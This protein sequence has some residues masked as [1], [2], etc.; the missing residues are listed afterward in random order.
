[1][2]GSKIPCNDHLSQNGYGPAHV[3]PVA[4]AS[5]RPIHQLR[6]RTVDG[7]LAVVS[8]QRGVFVPCLACS[9][10]HQD[11]RQVHP[12]PVHIIGSRHRAIGPKDGALAVVEAGAIDRISMS[13]PSA[14]SSC[15][16]LL[17]T[18]APCL[19]RAST[20]PSG[21][22]C[23]HSARVGM[24]S[25]TTR[26]SETEFLNALIAHAGSTEPSLI[27]CRQNSLQPLVTNVSRTAHFGSSH[28][29][30]HGDLSQNGLL[31]VVYCLLF[32]VHCL[33]FIVRRNRTTSF[34]DDWVQ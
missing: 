27:L 4:R 20:K 29:A 26:P 18:I 2:E 7:S 6:K 1:M 21:C 13:Q 25:S 31:F 22:S 32:I 10:R 5:I 24:S 33:L 17:G 3:H 28:R 16:A 11:C 8:G 14:S 15:A 19:L 12:G 30:G 34:N 9:L 23:V